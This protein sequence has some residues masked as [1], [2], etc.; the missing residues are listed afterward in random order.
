MSNPGVFIQQG[1]YLSP[2]LRL[3]A[4]LYFFSRHPGAQGTSTKMILPKAAGNKDAFTLWFLLD[5]TDPCSDGLGHPQR[6][7]AL[8]PCGMSEPQGSSRQFDR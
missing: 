4:H 8:E 1:L 7:R 2:F 6:H 3:I 5:S